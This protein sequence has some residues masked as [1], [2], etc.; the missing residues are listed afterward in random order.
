MEKRIYTQPLAEFETI[1]PK[2]DVLLTSDGQ[3]NIDD[4]LKIDIGNE[5]DWQ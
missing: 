1:D 5:A 3:K 2:E 4:L